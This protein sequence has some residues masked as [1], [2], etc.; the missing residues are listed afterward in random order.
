VRAGNSL[1]LTRG[2]AVEMVECVSAS[3]PGSA[4]TSLDAPAFSTDEQFESK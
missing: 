3:S 1:S 4:A 2:K